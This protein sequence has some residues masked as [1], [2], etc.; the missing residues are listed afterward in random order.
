MNWYD[1]LGLIGVAF[2]LGA[3]LALQL[4]RLSSETPA[5]SALNAGGAGLILVSLIYDFNLSAAV[6]EAAWLLISL[7][8]LIKAYRV[9][10]SHGRPDD[11]NG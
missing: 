5:F 9:R 3:Y 7:F 1:V 2:I 8:G 11:K 6:I 10:R 4:G